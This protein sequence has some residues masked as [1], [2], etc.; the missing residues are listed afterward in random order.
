MKNLFPILLL[1]LT[2]CSYQ[3]KQI[4]T[5]NQDK[6]ISEFSAEW[7]KVNSKMMQSWHQSKVDSAS[8]KMTGSLDLPVPFLS[9]KQGRN[10]LFYWDTYFTN[11]GL[12]LVDSLSMYAKNAVENQFAEVEQV[13]YV[14]NASE[15]WAINRSQT[16]FLSMMAREAYENNNLG[17]TWLQHAYDQ[18]LKEYEFWTDSTD[19]A[20]ENHTTSIKGLQRFY[21][22]ATDEELLTFYGQIA[23]RFGFT[24]EVPEKEKLALAEAWLSEAETGMDFTPRFENRCHQFVAVDLNS[25]L[26]IYE[27]NF[28]WMARELGLENERMWHEKAGKRKELLTKYCWNEERG[29]FMDYDFVN[30]RFSNVASIASFYP[31]WAGLATEEQAEKTVENL[32][33]FEYAYGPVICEKT[34]QAHLYQ[35]DYPAGWPPMYYITTVGLYNYGFMDDAKRIASKYLDIVSKNFLNPQPETFTETKGDKSEKHQREPGFVYE[36]YNVVEGSIYDAEY[37]S[38]TFQGWSY[39]VYVWSLDFIK[40]L[41]KPDQLLALLDSLS[42]LESNPLLKRH[43]ESVA[44][45]TRDTTNGFYLSKDDVE[46]ASEVLKFFQKEGANWDTYVN[47][48]RPLMMAFKSPTDGKNSFYSLFIPREFDQSKTDYPF[49][50]ELHGSGGGS[51][52]N[53]RKMLFQPLQPEI[54]GVTSQG[55]RK[56]GLYVYPWGRGDRGY[57]DIAETD[58]VEVLA[59]FEDMFKTDPNR[60]YLYGFSMGGGG[61]FRFAQKD[62][63]RWA[64]IGI[65]SGAVR[66]PTLKEAEL[67]KDTPVWLVWGEEERLAEVNRK[68]KDLF[69]EA[70]VE[71]K[72]EEVKGVGHRYLGE[73][74]EDLMEFLQNHQKSEN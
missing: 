73:Y 47:N 53:P 13:G 30:K 49:Y 21:H 42:Q 20:I 3:E 69:L 57:R 5:T 70:G 71:V 25:N 41:D 46:S 22:H 39:G 48:A 11:A 8:W 19:D 63:D 67:F 4:S 35:W 45:I 62:I 64:A 50:L 40:K 16:P 2:A 51:N 34:E 24:D 10:V 38:R 6:Y 7:E 72:W 28:A 54:K 66:N 12:L 17:K 74:Q 56:E 43:F 36:K 26:Y 68:L 60:Q 52:N 9:I 37:P 31:L 59:D 27:K 32:D 61:T 18:L 55:Y 14:P 58:I 15:P 1:I 33:L 29:L 65:Y 23:P 44:L